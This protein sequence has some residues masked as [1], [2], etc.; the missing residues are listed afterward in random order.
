MKDSIVPTTKGLL[1]LRTKKNKQ[2]WMTNDILSKMDEQKAHKLVDRDKYNHLNKEIINDCRKAK[3]IWLNK[4]CEEIEE[5]EKHHNLKEM[6][7]KVK[8]LWRN[9]KYN[10]SNGC[11][12]DKEGNL[13]FEEKD[14]ANRWKEYITELYDDNRAE[15]PKFAM[16][17]GYNILQEEVQKAII[18]LKNGKAT[19]SDEISTEMLKALDDCNVKAITKLVNILYN[20]GCIPTELEKSIFITLPKKAKSQDCADQNPTEDHTKKHS[21]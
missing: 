15:M 9:K 8:E 4:Q 20:T 5:L 1:P 18:S 14:V 6:H 2:T 21:K 17:T 13:L 11:I 12:M 10:N 3:E 16:T 7:A 19:G